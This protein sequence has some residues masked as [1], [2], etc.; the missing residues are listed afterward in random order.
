MPEHICETHPEFA[1]AINNE[2]TKTG[3]QVRVV[4]EKPFLVAPFPKLKIMLHEDVVGT[5][6]INEKTGAELVD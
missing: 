6:K 1:K 4:Y 3:F 5:K 2:A